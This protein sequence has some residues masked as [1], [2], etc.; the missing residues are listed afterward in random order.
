MRKIG[1]SIRDK[2]VKFKPGLQKK[3]LEEVKEKSGLTWNQLAK[4]LNICMHTIML[5][6]K[7]EKSTVPYKIVKR[8]IKEYSFKSWKDVETNWIEEILSE[9][10]RQKVI[11]ERIKKIIKIPEKSENFAE[12]LGIILGDGHL[13]RKTLTITGNC[14]EIEYY[15]YL[16]KKIK[17][18]F[19]LDSNTLKSKNQNAIQLKVHSVE[20]TKFL[21]VNSFVLGDKIKNKASLPNWIFEKKEF[22]YGALRGLFDTDGGIYQ[23]QKGYKRAIIEFQ[24]DSPYIRKDI[25]KMLKEIGFISSKSS[26]NIRIQNQNEIKKFFSVVGSANPKNIIRYNYF[27]QTGE[28]PLKEKL[29]KEITN[30]KTENPFKAALV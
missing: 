16:K 28:I 7:N 10:W 27:I 26:G 3:F 9:D 22:I 19:G 2:R 5:D 17:E 6:W 21:I 29:K 24:T 13:E 12:I 8:L 23:K 15:T 25:F 20:L 18:I 1:E 4:K 30:L 11:E 14:D